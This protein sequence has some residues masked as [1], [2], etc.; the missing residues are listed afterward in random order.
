MIAAAFCCVVVLAG[1]LSAALERAI[2]A[3]IEAHEREKGEPRA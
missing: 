3:A 2:E 1:E